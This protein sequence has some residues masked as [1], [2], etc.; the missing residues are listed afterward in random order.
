M[1]MN[2]LIRLALEYYLKKIEVAEWGKL[3]Y[4]NKLI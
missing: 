2:A 1:T 3:C 4:K